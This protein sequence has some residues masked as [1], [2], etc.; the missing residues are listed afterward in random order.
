M[1]SCFRVFTEPFF[2]CPLLFFVNIFFSTSS[3]TNLLGGGC[4]VTSEDNK[5]NG[6]CPPLLSVM[7][8]KSLTYAFFFGACF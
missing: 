3:I 6:S 1:N 4:E 8:V 2:Y 7:V 5:N